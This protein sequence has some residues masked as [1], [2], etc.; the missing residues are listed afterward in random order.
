MGLGYPTTYLLACPTVGG[1]QFGQRRPGTVMMIGKDI[2][3]DARNVEKAQ[4]AGQKPAHGR[5]I[6]GIKHCSASSAAAGDLI[7]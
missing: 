6:G 1:E 7:T 5:L 3:A 4:F 2:P